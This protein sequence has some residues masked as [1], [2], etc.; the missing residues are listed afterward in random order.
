MAMVAY[1]IHNDP[2]DKALEVFLSDRP[3]FVLLLRRHITMPSLVDLT[4]YL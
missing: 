2:L 4:V 3:F 1:A